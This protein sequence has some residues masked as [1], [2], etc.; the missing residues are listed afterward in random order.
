MRAQLQPPAAMG[1]TFTKLMSRLFSKQEMRILVRAV[2]PVGLWP[3]SPHS[4]LR[5]PAPC[6]AAACAHASPH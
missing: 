2:P 5:R 6:F 4:L 3:R 1:L